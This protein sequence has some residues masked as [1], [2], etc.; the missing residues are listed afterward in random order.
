M[1]QYNDG[2]RAE[3]GYRGAARDCSTRAIAIA[4]GRSYQDVYSELTDLAKTETRPGKNHGSARTG[5][6]MEVIKEY[7]RSIG[8]EWHA[9]MT[10]GS[11]CHVHL[12]AD[13]L[14]SGRI[15]ARVSHHMVAVI[16]G[17]INDT[18]DPSRD[19][20]RCVYGYFSAAHAA[21]IAEIE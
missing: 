18:H 16:D 7:M 21:E 9:T 2:G 19:G 12:R 3:A 15:V 20:T 5:V 11:G 1:Y 14:P 6:S 17:I 10:I 8:W 4:T 13:E